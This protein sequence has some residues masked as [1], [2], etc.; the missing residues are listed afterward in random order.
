MPKGRE[1]Q[2]ILRALGGEPDLSGLAAL[3]SPRNRKGEQ[4]LRWLD[5]SGLALNL[6]IHSAANLAA[7]DFPS[8]WRDALGRR[9]ERNANRLMDMLEEFQRLNQAFRAKGILAVTLKGFSLVPDFCGD[10]RIRHQTD[11][12]FLV[13]SASVDAAA[14][15]LGA[16][17]YSTPRLSRSEE[18]CFTTPLRHIPSYK[19]DL[20]SL[21]HHRQVDLHVSPWEGSRW[22]SMGAPRDCLLQAVPMNLCGV[23]FY[24]LSLVDRFLGQVF[25]SFRHS[26][27][28]WIRLS[29]LLE[30]GRCMELHRENEAL[31][32]L[33][34]ERA[35]SELL[36]KRIFAFVLSL[37]NR[38]FD[39]RIPLQIRAWAAEGMT[40]SM[41]S[42]L[43]HLSE[44]WAIS[45]WPGNLSNLFLASEFIPDASLRNKYLAS[46]LFPKRAQLSI[47]VLAKHE[48]SESVAWHFQ[49][50]QYVAFRSTAHFRDLLRLPLDQ[51][52]WKFAQGAVRRDS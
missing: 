38:L 16:F 6:P 25:H 46:R 19:D 43:D 48:K 2:A 35:G 37:T 31:W 8:E 5:Q 41:R 27:R 45:D 12:D 18:S 24:A 14:E 30:I 26:F 17:G 29:W 3:P 11:F 20:Y 40:P 4:L 52:R 22:M 13:A 32:T 42:W 10:P 36:T 33:V 50:W 49:R 51:I 15:V 39:F 1:K 28:S 34:V 21:Q 7:P 9:R 23:G 44:N 47:G